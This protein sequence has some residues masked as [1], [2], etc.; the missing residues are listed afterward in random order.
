MFTEYPKQ[1]EKGQAFIKSIMQDYEDIPKSNGMRVLHDVESLEVMDKSDVVVRSITEDFWQSVIDATAEY[2]VCAVGTPGI[3][4]TTTTCIL[5]RLLLQ[6]G[7]K[8]VYRVLGNEK[9]GY[10]YMFIPP[11]NTGTSGNMIK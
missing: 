8:V 4:K 9:D 1:Q 6:Q 11:S 7:K 10:L 2:R 5:I 3:G